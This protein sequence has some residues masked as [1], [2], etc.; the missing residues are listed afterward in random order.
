MRKMALFVSKFGLLYELNFHSKWF[1]EI[2]I[3][4]YCLRGSFI[5]TESALSW[6][7]VCVGNGTQE[8][9]VTG[10]AK[11]GGLIQSQLINS[12]L[13]PLWFFVAIA[14]ACIWYV[15]EIP[16]YKNDNWIVS[17]KLEMF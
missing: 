5:A 7:G 6:D 16:I 14:G 10:I 15:H 9:G 11:V 1:N 4:M 13:L 3:I 2:R 8:V 17:E 12:A